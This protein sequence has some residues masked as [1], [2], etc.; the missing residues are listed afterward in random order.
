M[1]SE[2]AQSEALPAPRRLRGRPP[3]YDWN[4]IMDGQDKLLF[5][6]GDFGENL[7]AKDFRVQVLAEANRR[8]L[9]VKTSIMSESHLGLD[10][11][12]PRGSG[13]L[14]DQLFDGEVHSWRRADL[15]DGVTLFK[16]R[17][18]LLEEAKRRNVKI[19]TQ[20]I[21]DGRNLGMRAHLQEPYDG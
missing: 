21:E 10:F 17:V 6:G 1:T 19:R 20:L 13:G 16:W 5:R 4:T 7:T 3:K 15:K 2:P 14:M 12:G 11:E 9:R 8:N 18:R